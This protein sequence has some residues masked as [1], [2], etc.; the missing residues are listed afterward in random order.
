[1]RETL[2]T[3]KIQSLLPEQELLANGITNDYLHHLIKKR[4]KIQS[5]LG[6]FSVDLCPKLRNEQTVIL[7]TDPS[8][9]RGF[10]FIVLM[11]RNGKITIF[12][13]INDSLELFPAFAEYLQRKKLYPDLS[14]LRKKIQDPISKFCGIFCFD[15]AL[16]FHLRVRKDMKIRKKKYHTDLKRLYENDEISYLNVVS[17]IK[18]L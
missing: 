17:Q 8:W 15:Y 2:S 9:G 6:V 5:C 16:T 11:K 4:L 18:R 13:S 12:D 10:H 3:A 1:M 14:A 7:N